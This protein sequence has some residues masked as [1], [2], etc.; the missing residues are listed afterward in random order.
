MLLIAVALV[1]FV[2]YLFLQD[3]RARL[4]PMVVG[5][6]PFGVRATLARLNR[7]WHHDPHPRAALV[8]GDFRHATKISYP[9]AYSGNANANSKRSFSVAGALAVILNL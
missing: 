6:R 1:I 5:R 9:F 4:I 8:C 7:Q 3:W 2:V